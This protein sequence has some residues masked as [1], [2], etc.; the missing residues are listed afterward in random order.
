M[1]TNG[2]GTVINILMYI[3][4][5]WSVFGAY[6]SHSHEVIKRLTNGELNSFQTNG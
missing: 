4:E 3:I 1:D 6:Y 5:V 2:V